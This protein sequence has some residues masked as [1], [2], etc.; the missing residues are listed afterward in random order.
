MEHH[1]PKSKE[2]PHQSKPK[3]T[4]TKFTRF[5]GCF[6]FSRKPIP[7]PEKKPIKFDFHPERK[8]LK[9]QRSWFSWPWFCINNSG[10]KTVPLDSTVP[11]SNRTSNAS[12]S[13]RQKPVT[14]PETPRQTPARVSSDRA[15][16]EMP[17]EQN[18]ADF[19]EGCHYLKLNDDGRVLFQT[20]YR[21]SE[22]DIILENG[23]PLDHVETPM[24]GTCKKRLCFCRKI[25]ALR[26]GTNHPGSPE[27]KAKSLRTVSTTRSTS[28]PS[29]AHEKS[30]PNTPARSRVMVKKPH[31]ENEKKFDPLVGMS[32]IVVT[33][34]IMLLWGKLCAI[35]CT[36][37][38]F[39]FVPRLRSEDDTVKNDL[40]TR[41]LNYDS[42]GYKKKVI[43]EGFLGR[44]RRSI[45]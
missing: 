16:K 44:N 43:L 9:K 4:R 25:D 37:A 10:T 24:D 40:R 38:W 14:N 28:F 3:R 6:G 20:W 42:E 11:D 17:G 35:L 45:S 5:L 31:K 29:P 18:L 39:Y 36:S 21:S 1:N 12:K 22:Q 34:M 2:Q 26:T 32:I 13:K 15:P 7:F 41:E 23:K 30:V 33:L 8:K 27:A 19:G